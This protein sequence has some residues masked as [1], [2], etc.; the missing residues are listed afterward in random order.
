MVHME[1]LKP[2]PFCGNTDISVVYRK[3]TGTMSGDEGWLAE[4][5]CLDC[6]V[7]MKFWA[8]RKSWA[9]EDFYKYWNRRPHE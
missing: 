7:T 3:Q 4:G 1:E 2:C 6:H 5:G 9:R 8:L